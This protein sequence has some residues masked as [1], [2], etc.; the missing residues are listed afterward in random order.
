MKVLT[1]LL[2]AVCVCVVA[3]A[4]AGPEPA[5]QSTPASQPP[6]AAAAPSS[7]PP[8]SDSTKATT[9]SSATDASST[10]APQGATVKVG[11]IVL[12]DKTLTN[13]QVKE[14]LARGYKPQAAGDRIVYCRREAPLGSRFEQKICQTPEQIGLQR[15]EGKDTTEFLQRMSG[16]PTGK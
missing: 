8:A 1:R 4:F 12:V 11:K 7:I 6:A 16:T 5:D 14:L 13:A 3:Q 9:T 10:S 15:Q 2:P